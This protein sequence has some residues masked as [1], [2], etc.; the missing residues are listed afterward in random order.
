MRKVAQNALNAS[1]KGA[2]CLAGQP[3]PKDL[4]DRLLHRNR[5][6]QRP[7]VV[8][9]TLLLEN[10]RRAVAPPPERGGQIVIEAVYS[11][12]QS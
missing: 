5:I 1:S 4:P 2:R 10:C 3:A 9:Q 12:L 6:S 8:D 11:A 7:E